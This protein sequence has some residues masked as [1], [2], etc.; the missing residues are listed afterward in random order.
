MKKALVFSLVS[1]LSLAAW[2]HHPRRIFNILLTSLTTQNCLDYCS[3]RPKSSQILV[4][5]YKKKNNKGD[6]PLTIYKIH[7]YGL[8]KKKKMIAFEP[9]ITFILSAVVIIDLFRD[10]FIYLIYWWTIKKSNYTYN[11]K[12]KK[13]L[14]RAMVYLSFY[15]LI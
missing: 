6:F 13:N 14:T 10:I 5:L 11:K 7:S 9:E 12:K 1:A 8:F 4:F 3:H 2:L 15:F